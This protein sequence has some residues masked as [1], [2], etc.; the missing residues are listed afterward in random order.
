M[1]DLRLAVDETA[2]GDSPIK[3]RC[4]NPA[5]DDPT[6]SLAVYSD[7]LHCYGCGFHRNNVDEALALLLGITQAEAQEA[8][9]R[10]DSKML[11]GY[12]E[13]VTAKARRDPMPTAY[14]EMY[15]RALCSNPDAVSWLMERGLEWNTI[16]Q[17]LIG[18]TGTHYTIPVFDKDRRLLTI[19]FRKD[20][21][22][23]PDEYE[24]W[25]GQVSRVPKYQGW[26]G[27]NGLY[28]Y[29]EHWLEHA[30]EVWVA[31]GELDALR[32]RQWGVKAC[33]ATNGARQSG[34]VPAMLSDL[35]PKIATLVIA[36]DV[37]TSGVEA[38]HAVVAAARRLGMKTYRAYWWQGK[39]VTEALHLGERIKKKEV[40]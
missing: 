23:V 16:E 24:L 27:R 34:R 10:Y 36:T 9:P 5:H 11:D 28:L 26:T 6:A 13:R 2:F 40:W 37:D 29:G 15:H 4:L 19:R 35:F 21:R 7:H 25:N 18:H 12:R 17:A 8:L 22:V 20:D 32:L 14:A 3:I 39:D 38:A 31:E 1:I 33:S 30:D